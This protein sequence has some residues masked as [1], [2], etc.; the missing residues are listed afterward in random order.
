MYATTMLP[1]PTPDTTRHADLERERRAGLGLRLDVP[2]GAQIPVATTIARVVMTSS[3]SSV[4]AYPPAA[5]A[6][7]RT[8]RVT[9]ISVS[10]R[11][12]CCSA[13]PARSPPD[14]P[15]GKPR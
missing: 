8:Q 3:P 11:F 12:A 5:G 9:R 4:T 7:P 6:I 1:S 2:A 13:R 14:T 10:K 15:A